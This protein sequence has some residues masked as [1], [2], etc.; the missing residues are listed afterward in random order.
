MASFTESPLSVRPP[1]LA[2]SLFCISYTYLIEH[3]N[4]HL[5]GEGSLTLSLV[6]PTHQAVLLPLRF[7]FAHF[8]AR[9]R[10]LLRN[11]SKTIMPLPLISDHIMVWRRGCGRLPFRYQFSG[12]DVVSLAAIDVVCI[13]CVVRGGCGL[14]RASLIDMLPPQSLIALEQ[15][16]ANTVVNA[17]KLMIILSTPCYSASYEERLH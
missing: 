4:K 5:S 10:Q 16:P 1:S 14:V 13:N 3:L 8:Y 2:H 9:L 15:V 7:M 11:E 17:S 12:I 6:L